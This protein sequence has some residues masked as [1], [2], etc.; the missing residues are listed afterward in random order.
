MSRTER[1]EWAAR[2]E[3]AER[4]SGAG[5]SRSRGDDERGQV[6][7]L[8]IGFVAV[9]LVAIAVVID[10]SAAYLQRQG[11]D[12]LADGA[13]LQGADM[14]SVGAY[15]EGI[16]DDRLR[17]ERGSAHDA[18]GDYLDRV[19]ARRRYPGLTHHVEV[20]AAAGLV[21]VTLIAPLDL[22]LHVPGLEATPV[23]SASGAAAVTV[24]RVP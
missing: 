6:S 12:T 15:R 3:R 23:V 8:I 21:R 9:L 19:G 20:D 2:A 10:A 4:T 14:G 5:G 1:T 16:P 11:L 24:Q 18:V 22:P 17:Q 7:L 13:A